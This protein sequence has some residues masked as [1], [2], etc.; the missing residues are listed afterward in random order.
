MKGVK[1]KKRARK[2]NMR[3]EIKAM[4]GAVYE[5]RKAP[6]QTAQ[7]V[8]MLESVLKATLESMRERAMEVCALQGVETMNAAAVRG[9]VALEFPFF[10]L[11][12]GS[13][14]FDAFNKTAEDA[15]VKLTETSRKKP[16]CEAPPPGEV[17]SSAS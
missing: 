16:P 3:S 17:S 6:R 13:V 11:D 12:D 8:S 15:V 5:G 9:G 10:E 14:A 4:I 7:A 2:V 1:K